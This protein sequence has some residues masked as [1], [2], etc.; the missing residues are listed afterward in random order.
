M[1]NSVGTTS[2]EVFKTGAQNIS[3]NT[4]GLHSGNPGTSSAN[5][6]PHLCDCGLRFHDRDSL[7]KHH[8]ICPVWTSSSCRFCERSFDSFKGRKA[9]EQKTHKTQWNEGLEARLL[10]CQE[11]KSNSNK[12]T[13]PPPEL[14]TAANPLPS[15]SAC[16]VPRRAAALEAISREL[17]P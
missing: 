1:S 10:V 9:H 7:R 13:I 2:Q 16:T 11:A 3:G 17:P 12:K 4:D 8:K 6:F 15:T 14:R 5:Y